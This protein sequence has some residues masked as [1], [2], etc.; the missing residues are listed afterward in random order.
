MNFLQP[1]DSLD[2]ATVTPAQGQHQPL[3]AQ[4]A[5]LQALETAN[6]ELQAQLAQHQQT[7]AELQRQNQDLREQLRQI[8]ASQTQIIQTEK[9]ASLGQLVAGIAHEI[10]NPI[11]FIHGNLNPAKH[12]IA[13]LLGLLHLYQKSFPP[14]PL[15]QQQIETIDLEFLEAD[16]PKLLNSITVGSNRIR[17]IVRSL[18]SF[19][20]LDEAELKPAD[21]HEGLDSTLFI[22]KSRFKSK[23]HQ[24][25]KIIKNYAELPLVECYPGQLNQV[26]LN[27][28]DNA[29]A[30][31][32]EKF[33]RT[34]SPASKAG[35]NA[36]PNSGSD[37]DAELKSSQI[38]TLSITTAL[39][40]TVSDSYIQ[41]AILDNGIGMSTDV[42][43]RIFD[44]FFTTKPIGKG[45]GLGLSIS[46][47]TI[48]DRHR[49]SLHCCS[50]PNQGTEMLIQIPLRCLP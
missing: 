34:A 7:E 1:S 21:I 23:L 25:V 18:R 6:R 22:L 3:V 9:M 30:A 43:Q 41:I 2:S 4:H 27:I 36:G 38:P 32:E 31:L 5:R 33:H 24:D 15:I 14:T 44:P 49:G 35:L 40:E 39:V 26:F 37:P 50:T 42:K 48:V 20:R 16:L 45:T 47:Q 46:Y 13:D 8:Q 12:Y 11:N 17:E 29:I 28:I 10:N 19:A